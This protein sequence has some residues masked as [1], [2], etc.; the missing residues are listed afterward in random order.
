VTSWEIEAAVRSSR[1]AVVP[2]G[3][4]VFRSTK[5]GITIIF[6]ADASKVPERLHHFLRRVASGLLLACTI[7]GGSVVPCFTRTWLVALRAIQSAPSTLG[8]A[9][10]HIWTD[11]PV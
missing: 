4:V 5:N 11:V 2:S 8:K 3:P 1:D 10:G 6:S 9:A 7:H